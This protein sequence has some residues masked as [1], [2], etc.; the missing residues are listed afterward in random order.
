MYSL[1]H[2]LALREAGE[3]DQHFLDAL[4]ATSR[5]DLAPPGV[6]AAALM[7]LL[8]MQQQMQ[9]AGFRNNFPN[10][11]HRILESAGQPIGRVVVDAS[12]TDLRL[13]DIA[14]LPQARRAGAA[15]AVLLAMQSAARHQRLGVSLAV[16]KTNQAARALY[17]ALGF[18][19]IAQDELFEQMAWQGEPT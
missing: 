4:Y 1:P 17:L 14:I 13:V 11:R 8:K 2:P 7:P 15:R 12:P 18:Q 5:E 3:Q 19:V 10:A 16:S 9:Q 6:D